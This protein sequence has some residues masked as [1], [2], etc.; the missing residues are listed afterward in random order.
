M[1]MILIVF[2][3]V[4]GIGATVMAAP[5]DDIM[6]ALEATDAPDVYFPQVEAYLNSITISPAQA[7]AVITR[8]NNADTIANGVTKFSK[9]TK[10]QAS[11]ILAE[12]S[13]AAQVLSLTATYNGSTLYIKDATN[14]T[15]FTVSDS[16]V[17]KQTG[18]DYSIVLAGAALIILAG[19]VVFMNRKRLVLA[20]Q[21]E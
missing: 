7:T 13:A 11:A 16:D 10:A 1:A 9:L 19:A 20:A 3:L 17:I 8:I 21:A 18:Y 15:V 5:A 12:I 4:M 6:T 2:I 14:K